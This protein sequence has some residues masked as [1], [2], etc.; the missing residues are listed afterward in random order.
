MYIKPN[1]VDVF[2]KNFPKVCERPALQPYKED[3]RKIVM[4]VLKDMIYSRPKASEKYD[5]HQMPYHK[6]L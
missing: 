5:Q 6:E 2:E 4:A 3:I 1:V